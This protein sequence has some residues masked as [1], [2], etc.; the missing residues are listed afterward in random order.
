MDFFLYFLISVF[1][2]IQTG[3]CNEDL[4][5]QTTTNQKTNSAQLEQLDLNVLQTANSPI[6]TET[7]E[8]IEHKKIYE[9]E[10]K[11]AKKANI[12]KDIDEAEY[13]NITDTGVNKE[14]IDFEKYRKMIKDT[15]LQLPDV[16]NNQD[17][18]PTLYPTEK[19]INKF[20]TSDIPSELL[21]N[22]RSDDN[23]HIPLILSTGDLQSIAK[24]AI[25][26]GDLNVIRGIVD[27]TKNPDYL[28]ENGQ[29]LLN[30]TA[31]TQHEDILRYLIY[32][33]ANLNIQNILG[34]TAL[35]NAIMQNQ[36]YAIKLLAK[37]NARLDIFNVY[38]YTPLMLSIVEGKNDIATYLIEFEQNF[39]QANSRGETVFDL[40]E[41]YNRSK[42]RDLLLQKLNKQSQSK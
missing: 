41:K 31:A 34:N 20:T 30:Y 10:L 40:A 9:E 8:D 23:K 29:T 38:G 12:S 14:D 28:L 21:N 11:R 39:S 6:L 36:K 18:T 22:T 42:V 2:T 32:S 1:F 27:L 35:H 37:N 25:D 16:E 15:R 4:K 3:I 13:F 26:N 5:Q 7:K 33:G 17:T 19:Q 24:T